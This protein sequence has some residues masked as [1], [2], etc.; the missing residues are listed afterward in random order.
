MGERR[1][2]FSKFDQALSDLARATPTRDAALYVNAAFQAIHN[3]Q[4]FYVP[5]A[6]RVL[7]GRLIDSDIKSLIR[8]PY[9][10]TVILSETSFTGVVPEN[11]MAPIALPERIASWKITIAF[12]LSGDYNRTLDLIDPSMAPG[13]GFGMLSLWLSPMHK[14]WVPMAGTCFCHLR[15]SEDGYEIVPQDSPAARTLNLAQE[16][17]DDAASTMNLCAMLHMHNVTATERLPSPKVNKRRL[18]KGHR[19]L[20]AY[21]V[22]T[23]DGESWDS[24]EE[25]VLVP[26]GASDGVR[27]HLRRGHI[28]RLDDGARLVWVRA[29]FV[30]GSVPGFVDKDYKLAG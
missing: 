10:C 8:L 21:H 19:P 28:R 23:V 7:A 6:A 30:R 13:P 15:S 14:L 18:A 24:L 20:Y 16:M 2:H 3:G 11:G 27:S 26:S 25:D 4:R 5:D 9:D 17:V 1:V 22:L 29:T 12:E